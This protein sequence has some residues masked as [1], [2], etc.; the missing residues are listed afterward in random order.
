MKAI[1]LFASLLVTAALPLAADESLPTLT[2]GSDTYSKVTVTS[3]TATHV[4]FSHSLGLGSAKLK[5]LTPEMQQHFH[6]NATNAAAAHSK[7]LQANALYR[8]QLE[9]APAPR[10]SSPAAPS[11]TPA[12]S[13]ADSEVQPHSIH[14]KSFLNQPAPA[15]QVEKW[16]TPEPDTAGKFV[17]VDFWA[18][19]CGPCRKSIPHLNTL[20]SIFKDRLVVIGLSDETEQAIRKMASPAIMYSVATDTRQR[21]GRAVEVRG[22]PHALLIDPKG[23]VR[24]EG[25]PHYLNEKNLAALL[26]RYGQ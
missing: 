23:V 10:P 15:L 14:A 25:M 3:V 9:Q 12:A 4:Y 16:L 2:V 18:T 17:L 7:Q 5:D 11:P 1:L 13:G 20:Y 19:W 21:T 24:F 6:Y 8:Q 22:I 26:E